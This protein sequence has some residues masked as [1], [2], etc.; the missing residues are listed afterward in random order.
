MH[1][2]IYYCEY[3][4]SALLD[5]CTFV[6]HSDPHNTGILQFRRASTYHCLMI[7]STVYVCVCVCVCERKG[8]G[9][10]EGERE[11]E[12]YNITTI[13]FIIFKVL[14]CTLLLIL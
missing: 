3:V 5:R 9:E 8:E 1:I 6:K 12:E 13:Q 14:M 4:Y 2:C 10:G 7:L 11:K